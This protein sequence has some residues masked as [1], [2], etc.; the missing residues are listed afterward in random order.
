MYS[1]AAML[2]RPG[3]D[4]VNLALRRMNLNRTGGPHAISEVPMDADNVELRY[5]RRI[6][7]GNV[8]VGMRYEDPAIS[9]DS[10]SRVIGF[11]SWQQGF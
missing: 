6:G 2:T 8:G 1:F 10:S 5:T 3:G 4:A 11:A 7:L 9:T